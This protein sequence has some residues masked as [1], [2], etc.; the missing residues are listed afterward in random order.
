MGP[1]LPW[2]LAPG[3]ARRQAVVLLVLFYAGVYGGP[4]LLPRVLLGAS[5][6]KL[7]PFVL[8]AIMLLAVWGLTR[9][10]ASWRESLGLGR[11]GR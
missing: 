1:P 7:S 6:P 10:E 9:Q 8:G 3:R 4:V 11:P 2:N 5:V